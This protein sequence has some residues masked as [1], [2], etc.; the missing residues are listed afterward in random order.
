MEVQIFSQVRPIGLT[1]VIP[2]SQ[3]GD[4]GFNSLIGYCG[5]GRN[6]YAPD[7]GSGL[8]EFK[9]RRS[10]HGG[11]S[12][13]YRSRPFKPITRVQLP[14]RRSSKYER[15]NYYEEVMAKQQKG[16]G[17]AHGAHNVVVVQLAEHRLAKSEVASSMLVDHSWWN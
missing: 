17:Q 9:S 10:P 15:R 8:C 11:Y 5:C 7:C 6:G 1:V 3:P 4:V 13:G 14:Y 16:V 12:N 2:G